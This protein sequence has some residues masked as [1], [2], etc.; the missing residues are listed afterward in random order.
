MTRVKVLDWFVYF[1]YL[2]TQN[3]K[4]YMEGIGR[5]HLWERYD[6]RGRWVINN[7]PYG[8]IKKITQL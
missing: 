7:T 4:V 5:I 3:R 1:Q 8:R 2:Y 6:M